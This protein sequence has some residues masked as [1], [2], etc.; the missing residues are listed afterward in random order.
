MKK[1]RNTNRQSKKKRRQTAEQQ[2]PDAKGRRNFLRLARNGAVG[3][4]AVG[5]IGFLLVQN[6]R[7][8][9]NE[10]DLSRV[11]NGTPTIVQIH[12]P[13]C[14]Q[15]RSLQRETRDALSGFDDND[16]DYVVANIRTNEGSR[17]AMKYSVP[18]V[19]LLLFDRNGRLTATLR[20]QRQSDELRL[21][22][23]QFLRK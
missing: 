11:G 6:V 19:T 7:G 20:G 22:F 5:G 3:L 13:Q 1:H 10:H 23:R 12:D 8:S 9:I 18:H 21:A 14:S 16:V 2:Q 17:F 15:C 4:A